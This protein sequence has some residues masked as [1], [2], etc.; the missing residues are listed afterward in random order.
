[1]NVVIFITTQNKK[2]AD[3][4]AKVLLEERLCACVNI[5]EKVDSLFWWKGSI[6]KTKESLLIVK[7]KKSLI[8]QL[9]KKVKSLHSYEVPEVICL[10]IIGGNKEYLDWLNGVTGNIKG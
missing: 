1:M 10:P 7:T 3:S 8:S 4:I 6:D 5:V 9:T 2:E